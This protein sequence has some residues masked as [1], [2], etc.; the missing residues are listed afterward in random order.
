MALF[1]RIKH[2]T[3]ARNNGI[4]IYPETVPLQNRAKGTGKGILIP[5]PE[6][7]E[8]WTY[9]INSP[10]SGTWLF[11]VGSMLFNKDYTDTPLAESITNAGNIVSIT[12]LTTT[13]AKLQTYRNNLDI[14]ADGLTFENRPHLIHKVVCIKGS[15]L[16]LYNPGDGLDIYFPLLA[17]EGHEMWIPIERLEF[18]PS[19]P[20][21][22]RPQ[23]NLLSFTSPRINGRIVREYSPTNYFRVYEYRALGCNVW[24]LIGQ[25]EWVCLQ[26]ANTFYTNWRMSTRTPIPAI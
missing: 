20:F 10:Q 12:A 23:E 3:T 16:Q 8:S 5:Y 4:S 2:D 22:A 26:K 24:G 19:L 13:H 18:F 1:A 14:P 9:G 15:T 6:K 25:N 21:I 7:W 11:S 17:R